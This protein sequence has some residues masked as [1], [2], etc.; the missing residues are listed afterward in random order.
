[1]RKIAKEW[2]G[3]ILMGVDPTDD[4][5]EELL[6]EE[7]MYYIR[8]ETF[9]IAGRITKELPSHDLNECIRK[10]MKHKEIE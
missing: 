3:G 4:E 5:T 7:D 6:T 9:K 1:M 2:C 8:E 10:Y